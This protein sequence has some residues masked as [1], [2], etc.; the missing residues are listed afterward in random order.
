MKPRGSVLIVE[1]DSDITGLIA[2]VIRE[3][4]YEV[5]TA[6]D[7]ESALE[8]VLACEPQLIFV[9]LRMPRMDGWEFVNQ[10]RRR[11]PALNAKVVLVSAVPDLSRQAHELQAEHWLRKPFHM[12]DILA[13]THHY[14]G[15]APVTAR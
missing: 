11:F 12:D 4:G 13:L 1:D 3:E 8:H 10:L 7:G 5:E 2:D 15:G 9:D 6:A 14:C